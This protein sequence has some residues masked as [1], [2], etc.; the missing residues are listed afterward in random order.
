MNETSNRWLDWFDAPDLHALLNL[1]AQAPV[2]MLAGFAGLMLGAAFFA[3]LQWTLR[4]SL[5]SPRPALW[6]LGSLLVRMSLLLLGLY[7]VSGGQWPRLLA[8]L[9]GV[10]GARFLILR[11]TSRADR[12]TDRHQGAPHAPDPR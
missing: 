9:I 3:G 4:K 10:I 1:L 2:L 7:L 11:L 12:P 6:L 5:E 8:G